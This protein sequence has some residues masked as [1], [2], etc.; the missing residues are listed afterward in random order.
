MLE[1]LGASFGF[2]VMGGM[3][4]VVALIVLASIGLLVEPISETL[5]AV[6]NAAA[7]FVIVLLFLSGFVKALSLFIAALNGGQ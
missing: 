2:L 6:S 4:G 1:M 5:C 3:L 7:V